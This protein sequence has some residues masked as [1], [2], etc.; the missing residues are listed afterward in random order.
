MLFAVSYQP[1][2]NA[3]EESQKRALTLFANWKPPAA[4]VLK[5]HYTN[6]DGS[7]GLA[8]VETESAAAAL[9]VHGAWTPFFE[10][11]VVPIVEI[12]KA[13]QIGFGTIKW[14]ESVK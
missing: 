10:F 1:R 5:A 12:E 7:G 11:K 8:L 14:R 2:A 9:E 13:V 3:T 6:A 4:Y